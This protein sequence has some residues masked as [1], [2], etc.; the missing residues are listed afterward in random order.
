[1]LQIE[2]NEKKGKKL[3]NKKE[4]INSS[5]HPGKKTRKKKKTTILR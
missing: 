4:K 3:K 1:L 5:E 2:R